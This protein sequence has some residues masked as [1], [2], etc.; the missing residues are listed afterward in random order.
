MVKYDS[1]TGITEHGDQIYIEIV[2]TKKPK[3]IRHNYDLIWFY[4]NN[5]SEDQWGY[6]SDL[7]Q[8]E[9]DGDADICPYHMIKPNT[10]YYYNF[11]NYEFEE[12]N[13]NIN[14]L[15]YGLEIK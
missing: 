14:I 8:E 2:D 7:I 10:Y 9:V 6:I 12:L 13:I 15:D 5:I 11:S 1:C 3:F 4:S